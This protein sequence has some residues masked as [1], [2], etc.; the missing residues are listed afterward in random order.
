MKPIAIRTWGFQIHIEDY[1]SEL[2]QEVVDRVLTVDGAPKVALFNG[3]NFEVAEYVWHG[4]DSVYLKDAQP[5]EAS[6]LA[7]FPVDPR[8]TEADVK[9][10]RRAYPN[11]TNDGWLFEHVDNDAMVDFEHELL[12]AVVARFAASV[13]QAQ[14]CLLYTSPSPRDS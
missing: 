7:Y 10:A 12:S 9:G 3:H 5:H 14:V 1:V 11:A 2:S 4:D 13:D 8:I 6:M